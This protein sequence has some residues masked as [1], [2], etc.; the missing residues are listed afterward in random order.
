MFKLLLPCAALALL[1]GCAS[2]P[3]AIQAVDLTP[4]PAFPVSYT[5]G[6]GEQSHG[7]LEGMAEFSGAGTG[8]EDQAVSITVRM[9][10]L[11]PHAV[12]EALG[13]HARAISAF[14]LEDGQADA[15]AESLIMRKDCST[16]TAPRLL[17]MEGQTGTIEVHN[18][19]SYISGFELVTVPAAQPAE[20]EPTV[21]NAGLIADPVVHVVRDGIKLGVRAVRAGEGRLSLELDLGM[22]NLQR[23]IPTAEVRAFGQPMTVQVPVQMAQR[24][25][26]AGEVSVGRTLALTGMAAGDGNLLLVLVRAEPTTLPEPPED[27]SDETPE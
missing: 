26:G 5:G 1:A 12:D 10:S 24:M 13:P 21:Q 15:L 18:E 25:T 23:P 7:I 4:E 2:A 9:M 20:G 6:I 19:V 16:I 3:P 14:T 17:I 22:T 11:A 27:T 8:S